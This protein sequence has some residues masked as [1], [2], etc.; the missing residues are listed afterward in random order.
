MDDF[1][2]LHMRLLVC[3]PSLCHCLSFTC[4][5][6]TLYKVLPAR[7]DLNH[8]KMTAGAAARL[9]P[10]LLASHTTC[11]EMTVTAAMMIHATRLGAPIVATHTSRAERTAF[12]GPRTHA[13]RPDASIVPKHPSR[14]GMPIVAA[15]MI[16]AT[17]LGVLIITN[18]IFRAETMTVTA[19]IIH[20]VLLT[21][22]SSP[23]RHSI[24][25]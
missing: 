24:Q 1:L 20:I 13:T 14:L 10:P 2:L 15:T 3:F 21:F 12:A 23:T 17:H 8:M 6:F 22:W 9:D 16:P 7:E 19:T 5:P 4:L 25:R 11:S 18:Q